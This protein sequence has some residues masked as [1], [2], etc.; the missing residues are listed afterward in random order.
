MFNDVRPLPLPERH[1][2]ERE[3]QWYVLSA[4]IEM[5]VWSVW[6]KLK[7]VQARNEFFLDVF[8]FFH[9]FTPHYQFLI[10]NS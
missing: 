9:F 7:D 3:E 8:S 2:C 10:P 6:R 1:V 4:G 5:C